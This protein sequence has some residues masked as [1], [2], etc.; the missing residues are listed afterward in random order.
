MMDDQFEEGREILIEVENRMRQDDQKIWLVFTLREGLG[1]S[2]KE[3]ARMLDLTEEKVTDLLRK[4][5]EIAGV[6]RDRYAA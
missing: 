2:T 1:Y 4:A 5:L 6:I 3:T